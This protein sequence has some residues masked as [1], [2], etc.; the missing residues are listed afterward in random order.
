MSRRIDGLTPRALEAL[1]R[2]AWPGNVRELANE[3]E[4]AILLADT[5]GPISDDLLSAHVH[6]AA[7]ATAPPGALQSKTDDFERQQI[8]AA[9]ER[10]N[11]VK[12]RVAEELGL[13]Y[14]GLMKKMRR[15]GL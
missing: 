13:S 9:L 12:M 4:R 11:G 1:Q 2:H 15:L 5:N 14:R 10:H 7:A 8:V 3:I 6:E